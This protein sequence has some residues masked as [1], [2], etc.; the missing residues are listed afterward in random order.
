VNDLSINRRTAPVRPCRLL[1]VVGARPNYMKVAPIMAAVR[2]HQ[3][4]GDPV[5]F[6]QCLVHTGQ[7][8]DRAL[9]DLFFEELGLPRP[10]VNL[11]VGSGSHAQQTARVMEAFEPVLEARRPDLVLVVGDVNSTLACALDARKLGIPVAHVEAG[12]RSGDMSMPEEINRR[13]TDA[14]SDLLFTTDR[15]ADACLR[16]E[17]A[18]PSVIHRVGNVM[19]DSLL[20]HRDKALARPT[21]RD[22]GLLDNDGRPGPYAVVT[23]HRPGNVDDRESLSSIAEALGR[24]GERMPVLFPVHPRTRAR[25]EA[26][27]LGPRLD[28]GSGIRLLEPAGYLDFVN[29]LAHARLVLTDSGGIQEETTIL[30]VP[31]LTLRPNTERPITIDEGTNRLVGNSG[32]EIAAAAE[33]ALADTTRVS[34]RPELWD[35][36][37]AERIV[38]VLADW[39]QARAPAQRPAG[40]VAACS[41][42]RSGP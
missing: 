39:W 30:G 7:H 23:L 21:L 28:P 22:L 14:I 1:H 18:D 6:E 31:C 2:A 11:G 34:R 42:G 29:L 40:A 4:R 19:I 35:G 13:A 32:A 33:A 5:T 26:F 20:A 15:I 38:A 24:I 3:Q 27:G 41:G 8:Y 36:H 17:G 12:L 25:I 37:A 9:S 10:D 16:R